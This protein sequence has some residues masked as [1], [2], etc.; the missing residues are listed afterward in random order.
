MAKS[1]S[2][3]LVR[4]KSELEG[5]APGGFPRTGTRKADGEEWR[6]TSPPKHWSFTVPSEVCGPEPGTICCG[7]MYCGLCGRFIYWALQFRDNPEA[8][9]FFHWFWWR[10]EVLQFERPKM[11]YFW[12]LSDISELDNQIEL[13][14]YDNQTP[15]F[16]R[17]QPWTWPS[18]RRS[19]RKTSRRRPKRSWCCGSWWRNPRRREKS[20]T[21]RPRLRGWLVEHL[22]EPKISICKEQAVV[23]DVRLKDV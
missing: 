11:L 2:R 8:M 16:P 20:L 10:S 23:G 6:G 13:E 15:K 1:I 4:T 18:S 19:R 5:S 12:M 17:L 22:V 14:I 9:C 7:L 3:R 21:R